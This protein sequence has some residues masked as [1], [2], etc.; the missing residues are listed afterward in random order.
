MIDPTIAPERIALVTGFP[1]TGPSDFHIE[2]IYWTRMPDSSFNDD[3]KIEYIRA[4]VVERMNAELAWAIRLALKA[5]ELAVTS[6]VASSVGNHDMAIVI[7]SEID[8]IQA[9]IDAIL[10]KHKDPRP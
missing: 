3:E 1:I 10:A 2:D 4:D 6:E 8:D 5:K 9:R 7:D